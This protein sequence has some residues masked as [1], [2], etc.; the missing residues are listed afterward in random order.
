MP[1]P[2]VHLFALGPDG[3]IDGGPPALRI[4]CFPC[5]VGRARACGHRLN[6]PMVSRRHCAFTERGGRVWVED[7]GSRNGTRLNGEPVL[8]ARPVE[9]GDRLELG[10]LAFRVRLLGPPARPAAPGEGRGEAAGAAGGG[11]RVLVVEDDAAVARAL[12]LQL[13]SWGCDVRVARDGAEALRAAQAEPPD[14]VL[15]D[16]GLPD[17]SGVEVARRLRSEAG[18]DRVRLVAVTGERGATEALRSRAGF[19]E[20]L[21]K[22]VSACALRDAL[23]WP[24][25][26]E[27]DELVRALTP[28]EAARRTGRS[29]GV[30]YSRRAVL[31][32]SG[33]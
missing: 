32:A 12:A 29:L 7:L 9:D 17:V 24:W 23:S 20:L 18:L 8:G 15:M 2:Q 1:E 22:P 21:V 13:E 14:T 10:R 27:E 6:D 25:T 33:G 5:E 19:E 26:P 4:N 3:D 16:I 11:R 28:A 31:R 30:V